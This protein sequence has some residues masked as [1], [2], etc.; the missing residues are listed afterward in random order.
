[1]SPTTL[2]NSGRL[3]DVKLN[4][5]IDIN[6]AT[7]DFNKIL[8]KD[9]G[10]SKLIQ[11]P[12]TPIRVSTKRTISGIIKLIND[13]LFIENAF[14]VMVTP[15][16]NN[17]TI[18]VGIVSPMMI[19]GIPKNTPP[20]YPNTTALSDCK[21]IAFFTYRCRP[22]AFC[23]LM[24]GIISNWT[25]NCRVK[26]KTLNGLSTKLL[27]KNK[28]TKSSVQAINNELHIQATPLKTKADF[29]YTSSI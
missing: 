28:Y 5:E 15:L 23:T 9:G 21:I 4:I 12:Y 10:V 19:P 24:A 22:I 13:F 14:L 18:I 2:L 8:T 27:P 20:I 29:L 1:M 17:E 25:S 7:K 16:K 26:R 3:N 11:I 6:S